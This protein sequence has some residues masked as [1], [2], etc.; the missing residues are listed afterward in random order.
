MGTP[1]Y[2]APELLLGTGHGPAVDW[3]SLGATLFELL[4][5]CPPFNAATPEEIFDNVLSRRVAWPSSPPERRG[6]GRNGKEGVDLDLGVDFDDG[7]FD[8]DDDDDDAPPALSADAR[9]LIER[10]LD[11]DPRT[12]LGYRG[13]Q[14]VKEHPWFSSVD[15]EGLAGGGGGVGGGEEAAASGGDDDASAASASSSSAPCSPAPSSPSAS[16]SASPSPTMA[17]ADAAG[18]AAAAGTAAAAAAAQPRSR[19]LGGLG[20]LPREE[21]KKKRTVLPPA[22]V[23]ALASA[24]D[25]GYFEPAAR[26]RRPVSKASMAIDATNSCS[27]SSSAG[28]A[29]GGGA[30]G[31]G[32]GIAAAAAR[33][34]LKQEE[35][36]AESSRNIGSSSADVSLSPPT[37]AFSK[38]A[39]SVMTPLASA[40]PSA[41]AAALAASEA[42]GQGF[43][44]TNVDLLG[45][46]NAALALQQQQQQQQEEEAEEE[47]EQ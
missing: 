44:F 28:G 10:L 22:F 1:D 47:E 27:L 40:G 29:G 26:D 21:K 43:A 46:A 38:T 20:G 41:D 31:A 14:E 5:G 6:G 19:S 13:A 36:E 11:P 25:T 32:I 15:W 45:A 12:R 37:A 34:L 17:T 7:D 16:A 30:G 3:W 35:E 23:P 9:D 24:E 18:P 2:L 39:C 33:A 42:L 8:D 4:T